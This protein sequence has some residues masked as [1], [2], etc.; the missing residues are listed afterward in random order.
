MASQGPSFPATA[1]DDASVGTVAW[2]NPTNITA[3]DGAGAQG[4]AAIFGGLTHWLWG[5]NFGFTIPAGATIQGILVE[6]KKKA[7]AGTVVDNQVQIALG[8]TVQGSDYADTSTS[9]GGSF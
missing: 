6:W 7:T 3:D 4:N 5:S 8:G 9:W 1:I 2:S